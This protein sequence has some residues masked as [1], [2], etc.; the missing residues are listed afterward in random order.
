MSNE[1]KS[2]F[3]QAGTVKSWWYPESEREPLYAHYEEQ[4]RWTLAQFNWAG[5]RVADVGTGKG[6]FAVAVAEMGATVYALDIAMEMLDVAQ[7]HARQNDVAVRYLQGDAEA[8][9]YPDDFFDIVLCMETIMHVPHPQKLLAEVR[10]ITKPA[11]HVLLSMTNKYRINAL[12]R[13]PETL[14]RRLRGPRTDEPRYMWSYSVRQFLR[15][16]TNADLNVR[17]LHGQGLF[18][19]NARVRLTRRLSIKLFPQPF[20]DWFFTRIEP[21]LRETPLLKIMGTVMA[22]AVPGN[23]P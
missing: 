1:T 22:I 5:K 18:Q 16:C 12:A 19:A 14:Y 15:F 13:L 10:R 7:Q 2:Y 3:R 9:P 4:L 6:R 20:A 23:Q 8:L 11:G 17:K 21:R